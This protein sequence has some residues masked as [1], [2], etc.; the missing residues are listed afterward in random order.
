MFLPR[1]LTL[2]IYGTLIVNVA[3]SLFS[4]TKRNDIT[5]D[6]K[7][8]AQCAGGYKR[9]H[10]EAKA[11]PYGSYCERCCNESERKSCAAKKCTYWEDECV[12]YPQAK[13]IFK[14]ALGW[15]DG[16][17]AMSQLICTDKNIGQPVK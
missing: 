13:D 15:R 12:M 11:Y 17:I 6:K 7:K 8:N 14:S 2:A 10:A 9:M 16:P 4:P 5:C 3:A 1:A